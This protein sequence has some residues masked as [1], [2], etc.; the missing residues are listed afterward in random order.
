MK[1]TVTPPPRKD[2]GA[3]QKWEKSKGTE[4]GRSPSSDRSLSYSRDG[5]PQC[6]KCKGYGHFMRDC[7]S[8]DFYVVGPNGLLIKKRRSL[9]ERS[10]T[11]DSPTTEKTLN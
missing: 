6:F 9:Q 4:R 3:K 5:P 8:G 7:P 10:K 2:T 11:S 1:G